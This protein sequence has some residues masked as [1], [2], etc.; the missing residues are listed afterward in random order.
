MI[1]GMSVHR[2]A[3]L[4]GLFTVGTEPGLQVAARGS[5]M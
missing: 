3:S 2:N 4:R 5:P 1:E